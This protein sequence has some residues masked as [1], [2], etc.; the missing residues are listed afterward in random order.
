MTTKDK[1]KARINKENRMMLFSHYQNEAHRGSERAHLLSDFTRQETMGVFA[2][3][4]LTFGAFSGV[5]LVLVF[6]YKLFVLFGG[7][8]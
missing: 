4:L 3:A 5:V 7:T 1:V 2:Q 8:P 6:T